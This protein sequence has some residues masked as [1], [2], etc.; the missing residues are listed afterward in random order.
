MLKRGDTGKIAHQM[1]KTLFHS[2][3]AQLGKG[4][5]QMR[6][7]HRS[8]TRRT[9]TVRGIHQKLIGLTMTF[10]LGVSVVGLS[11]GGGNDVSAKAK[12]EID[13]AVFTRD[14]FEKVSLEA[15]IKDQVLLFSVVNQEDREIL[16]ADEYC[17]DMHMRTALFSLPSLAK[18]H[19]SFN[20]G[21]AHRSRR[22]QRIAPGGRFECG[23]TYT[24][25]EYQQEPTNGLLVWHTNLFVGGMDGKYTSRS[26]S[27]SLAVELP[28]GLDREIPPAVD[29]LGLFQFSH[30]S[31]LGVNSP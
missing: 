26:F 28:I 5:L 17:F 20:N 8:D 19:G 31:A 22:M 3:F 16:V 21:I 14:G 11:A 1:V 9:V 18:W 23:L 25:T 24:Q 2:Q 12:T 6:N 27:G 30:R 29:T 7:L 13:P 4:D 15:Q 10:V